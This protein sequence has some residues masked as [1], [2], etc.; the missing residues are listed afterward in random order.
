MAE[1]T[2]EDGIAAG[3]SEGFLPS[4][5]TFSVTGYN[6]KAVRRWRRV[7]LEPPDKFEDATLITGVGI[8]DDDICIIGGDF[9]SNVFSLALDSSTKEW[10]FLERPEDGPIGSAERRILDIQCETFDKVPPTAILVSSSD[11]YSPSGWS[12]RLTCR[13]PEAVLSTTAEAIGRGSINSVYISITWV[14]VLAPDGIWGMVRDSTKEPVPLYGHVSQLEWTPGQKASTPYHRAYRD[15]LSKACDE[16]IE[17]FL[18]KSEDNST[19]VKGRIEALLRSAVTQVAQSL[20]GE[21]LFSNAAE[22][23]FRLNSALGF[24]TRLDEA[25]HPPN[26]PFREDTNALWVHRN[27][28]DI[29]RNMRSSERDNF[30]DRD[31]LRGAVRN[32]LV[33][34]WLHNIYLDWVMIDAL[35]SG[36]IIAT[37][38]DY[39]KQKGGISYALAD[40]MRWKI[41]ILRPLGWLV[42]WGLLPAAICY[43]IAQVSVT[44]AIITGVSWYGLPILGRVFTLWGRVRSVFITGQMMSRRFATMMD[45]AMKAYESLRGGMLHLD[46]VR[47]AFE[48][49]AENGVAWDHE[50]FY[51]LD[52]LSKEGPAVWYT[53]PSSVTF[54]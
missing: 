54:L 39:L 10:K 18:K 14:G 33:S 49:S 42:S 53:G 38:E 5:R 19:K 3:A 4:D 20:R 44:G 48:R 15:G 23:K 16:F 46:V 8:S 32:Y 26:G 29:L 45:E 11:R 1:G 52:R 17:T 22:L 40:G 34:P 7:P 30:V 2:F 6:L 36:E 12:W 51:L 9:A 41:M 43:G 21:D 13:I 28:S 27:I 25:L 47:R 35:S 31:D 37:A 24:L 50:I